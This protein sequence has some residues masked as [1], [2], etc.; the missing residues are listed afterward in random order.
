M[1]FAGTPA[2]ISPSGKLLITEAPFSITTFVPIVNLCLTVQL[3][4]LRQLSPIFV[5][6]PTMVPSSKLQFFPISTLWGVWF[7]H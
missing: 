4:P 6:P 5:L 1:D 7:H 3:N 2:T